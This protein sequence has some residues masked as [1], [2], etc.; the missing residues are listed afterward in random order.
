MKKYFF[1]RIRLSVPMNKRMQFLLCMRLQTGSDIAFAN[2]KNGVLTVYYEGRWKNSWL[3]DAMSGKIVEAAPRKSKGKKGKGKEVAAAETQTEKFGREAFVS[4]GGFVFFQVL[5]KFYPQFYVSIR[6]LR[7]AFVLF[8]ARKIIHKGFDSIVKEREANADTLTAT[9]VIA[10]VIAGKPE[11]SLTL[12][13]L[14]NAAEMLTSYAAERA[15]KHISDLLSLDQQFTWRIDADGVE[16]RTAI[17]DIRP[18]DKICV[19]LGEKVCIDGIVIEGSAAVDQASITGESQP[20]MKHKNSRVYAGSVVQNGGLTILVEKVGDDTSIARIVHL[21]EEA[22]TRRAPVQNFADR[23]ANMLVPVSFIGAA[24]V[25]GVTRDWQR[26]MNLLFIDF[27]C[28]LKLSTA[29]AVSAAIARAAQQGILV[30]GGNY[31]ETLADIDTI[32]LDKTGTITLGI[33]QIAAIHTTGGV[34][35]KE[36]LLLAGSIEKHS[37]HPLAVAIQKYI[38]DH[39]WE[40]PPHIKTETVVARGIKGTVADFDGG[41]GGTVIVGSRRFMREE[42]VVNYNEINDFKHTLG[43]SV[44]YI[45]RN[46]KFIGCIEIND[47]IRPQMKRT[48]NQLRR[49]GIDEI[50][51]LT[52]DTEEAAK[53]VALKMDLDSYYAEVLPEDKADIV[54]R[55]QKNGRVLMVG[56][57]INDAPALSF[58]DIGVALGG[59]RTDIAV[60][61]SDITINSDDPSKLMEITQ[62]G[63]DTMNMIRQNFTATITLNSV[64]MLLGALGRINPLIAAVIHNAATLAVVLNSGRILIPPQKG[65]LPIGNRKIK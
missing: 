34:K 24:L 45:A 62:I 46:N 3:T 35:E 8:S 53:E 63:D 60:E 17:E 44:V 37:L 15:R 48:L 5:K 56:D 7:S 43:S 11:S 26:V 9:A 16:R 57:G 18:N 12:L 14:S 65:I 13:S 31:I 1:R 47:P 39:K 23:M 40:A 2:I 27:S 61:S 59:R 29:T 32:V 25:Y 58:A 51:M 19:H 4:L 20:A 33:P 49:R 55:L 38:K 6:L 50:V 22:Q 64:A 30:K 36:L 21:V 52:G 54:R 42:N 41:K 28:G 10:S